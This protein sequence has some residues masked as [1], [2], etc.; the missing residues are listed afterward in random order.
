MPTI[1]WIDS[2]NITAE[3]ADIS[4]FVQWGSICPS[5]YILQKVAS[6]GS[7][8]DSVKTQVAN[9]I[10]SMYSDGWKRLAKVFS[11]NY[12]ILNSADEK[13]ITEI[14]DNEQFQ[15][16]HVVNSTSSGNSSLWGFNSSTGI[17]SDSDSNEANTTNS[18]IDIN[19]RDNVHTISRTG[20]TMPAQDLIS[21]EWEIW[22]KNYFAIV[23]NDILKVIASPIYEMEEN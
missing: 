4:F 21:K 10:Y 18:G 20:Q 23:Y 7:I 12:E 9:A 5:W 15:H 14:A 1:P 16:G 19:S 22:K 6:D 13:T 8:T 3:Q 2:L 17:P 11:L